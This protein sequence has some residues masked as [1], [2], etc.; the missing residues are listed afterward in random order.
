[1][2]AQL[3]GLQMDAN[4]VTTCHLCPDRQT[5]CNGPCACTVDG[6]D[7][8]DHARKGD[9]PKGRYDGL[10]EMPTPNPGSVPVSPCSGCGGG[11]AVKAVAEARTP[12]AM[13]QA[14]LDA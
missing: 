2:G 10:P 6:R 3:A 12:A 1:M 5:P 4:R 8:L 7:I 13:D 9:C 14:I 11:N